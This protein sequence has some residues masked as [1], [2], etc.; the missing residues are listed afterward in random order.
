MKSTIKLISAKLVLVMGVGVLFLDYSSAAL[1]SGLGKTVESNLKDVSAVGVL[2]VQDNANSCGL[3]VRRSQDSKS[4]DLAEEGIREVFAQ[5]NI[6]E[7]D[8]LSEG[9]IEDVHMAIQ[10]ATEGFPRVA[11][12]GGFFSKII[13]PG[14]VKWIGSTMAIG[15]SCVGG[16]TVSGLKNELESGKGIEEAAWKASILFFGVGGTVWGS[17]LSG[18]G[19]WDQANYRSKKNPTGVFAKHLFGT[20]IASVGSWFLCFEG[21][22]YLEKP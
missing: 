19:A 12:L 2:Y 8:G 11:S 3:V 4:F 18:L 22:E 9:E 21:R 20:A 7:C 13:T 5:N 15:A 14:A 17:V 1:T 6:P 16:A 10:M